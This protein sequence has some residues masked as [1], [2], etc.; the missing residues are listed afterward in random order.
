MCP[1]ESIPISHIS[2]TQELSIS[3][4]Q[5]CH[6]TER[7]RAASARVKRVSSELPPLRATVPRFTDDSEVSL[8][9]FS[10]KAVI[11]EL[12][13]RPTSAFDVISETRLDAK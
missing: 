10:S 7:A 11:S 12:C 1:S 6:A 8:R 3:W 9:T 4:F 13:A 5:L 2:T